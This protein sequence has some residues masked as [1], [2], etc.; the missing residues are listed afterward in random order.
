MG[1][2]HAID[3]TSQ[4]PCPLITRQ[5][6]KLPVRTKG[7]IG[8]ILNIHYRKLHCS[9][10]MEPKQKVTYYKAE[11]S[12]FCI[13]NQRIS[14]DLRFHGKQLFDITKKLITNVFISMIEFFIKKYAF[15]STPRRDP[16]KQITVY[17]T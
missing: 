8:V 11:K 16:I 15:S 17:Y 5:N 1:R 7:N 4:P 9:K 2:R 10:V 12:I 3:R 13:I 6:N 14:V